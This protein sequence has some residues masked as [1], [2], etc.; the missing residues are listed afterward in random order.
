MMFK[1]QKLENVGKIQVLS[2]LNYYFCW[3]V[4]RRELKKSDTISRTKGSNSSVTN[5]RII[6]HHQRF[7]QQTPGRDMGHL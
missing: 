7:V 3:G 5:K 2:Q 6:I 4:N 1:Q